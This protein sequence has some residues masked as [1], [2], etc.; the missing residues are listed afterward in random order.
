M[1]EMLRLETAINRSINRLNEKLD[2]DNDWQ[3]INDEVDSITSATLSTRLRKMGSNR[4]T[5]LLKQKMHLLELENL[6]LK[7][8]LGS[9]SRGFGISSPPILNTI[10]SQSPTKEIEFSIEHL[11]LSPPLSPN[12]SSDEA[13]YSFREE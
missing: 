5:E 7:K 4:E 13:K 12:L 3:T 2:P 10:E 6:E 1:R 11:N 8:Q 9:V